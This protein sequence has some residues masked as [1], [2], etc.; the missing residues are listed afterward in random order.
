M[1]L[2]QKIKQKREIRRNNQ[3][4]KTLG[5]PYKDITDKNL[6]RLKNN[7]ELLHERS[8]KTYRILKIGNY[9]VLADKRYIDSF[10][11][12][13][14]REKRKRLTYLDIDSMTVFKTN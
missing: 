4:L 11:L 5:F 14:L 2:L 3:V 13:S 6:K 12:K 9:H 1:K 8:G 10:K 7:A